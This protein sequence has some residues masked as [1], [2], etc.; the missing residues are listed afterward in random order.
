MILWAFTEYAAQRRKLATGRAHRSRADS[1]L[2]AAFAPRDWA[3]LWAV[4]E[5]VALWHAHA[6]TQQVGAPLQPLNASTPPPPGPSGVP[7]PHMQSI[8]QQRDAAA[9]DRQQHHVRSLAR[10][11]LSRHSP[12]SRLTVKGAP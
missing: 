12:T 1:S 5:P 9:G 6:F 8:P 2:P 4:M 7:T 10:L 3:R 11:G